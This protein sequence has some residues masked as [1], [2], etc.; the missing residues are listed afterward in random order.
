MGRNSWILI[1]P[2]SEALI[3][4][5]RSCGFEKAVVV[6]IANNTDIFNND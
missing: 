6:G 2:L 5:V 1:T 4:E 3:G